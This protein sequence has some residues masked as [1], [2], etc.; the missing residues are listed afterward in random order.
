[1]SAIRLGDENLE[2]AVMHIEKLGSRLAEK[3]VNMKNTH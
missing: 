2:K 1:M 3:K